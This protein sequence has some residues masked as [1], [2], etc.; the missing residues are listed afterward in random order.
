MTRGETNKQKQM[1]K[2]TVISK[3]LLTLMVFGIILWLGGAIIRISTAYDIYMPFTRLELKTEY[4]DAMRMHTVKL[5]TYGSLYTGAGFVMA[6]I[7]FFSLA[8][9]WRD[10]F[11]G[12]GWMFI[13]LV[14]FIMA[15]S[16]GIYELILDI[17]LSYLIKAGGA[18]F[19]NKLIGELFVHRLSTLA[20][21][22]SIAYMSA[23]SSMLIMIWRPLN[24]IKKKNTGEKR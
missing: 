6:F 8:Y 10:E 19:D 17:R 15:S 12:K 5:F 14:L 16:W 11:K 22:S 4:N 2:D 13:A 9:Y 18:A 21:W 3:I 20:P 7:G 1:Q 24:R 23:I